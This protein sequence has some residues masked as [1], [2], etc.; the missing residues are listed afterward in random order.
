[1]EFL[2]ENRE[3]LTQALQACASED[4]ATREKAQQAFAGALQEPIRKAVF[5]ESNHEGIYE[6]EVLAPGATPNYHMDLVKPGEEEGFIAWV[7]PKAGRIPDRHV[8]G[9][10][11]NVP[12]FRVSNAL[13]WDIRYMQNARFDVVARALNVYRAGYIRKNNTDAWRTI[14][15]AAADR[16]MIVAASGDSPFTGNA[17]ITVPSAPGQFT[18]ELISRAKTAMARGAGGNTMAGD[19]TD[20]YCSV[21]AMEDIRAWSTTEVD[22]FTRREILMAADRGIASLYGSV[23]HMMTEFGEGQEYQNFLSTTLSASL[24]D[25]T[26]EWALGLDLSTRDSF[27]NPVRQELVTMEDPNL[28]RSQ[29]MGVFGW[30]E[31]GFAILDARRVLLC[32][33]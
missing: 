28:Y 22:E 10:E 26:L 15:T 30:L 11:L 32:A 2:K 14:L 24:P 1:M 16:G 3:Q 18:K 13:S 33:F 6:R 8:E 20:L 23:V 19:M 7:L 9:D 17:S 12:T 21:E 4:K 31:H 29:R 5:D 27:V 25:S